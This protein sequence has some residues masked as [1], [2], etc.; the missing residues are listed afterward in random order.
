MI[1]F[2]RI[3]WIELKRTGQKFLRIVRFI[4]NC[5]IL[6]L[7]IVRR[8]ETLLLILDMFGVWGWI[9]PTEFLFQHLWLLN[10][11]FSSVGWDIFIISYRNRW[12]FGSYLSGTVP[13]WGISFSRIKSSSVYLTLNVIRFNEIII[14]IIWRLIKSLLDHLVSALVWW[15]VFNP[16]G[17]NMLAFESLFV[18]WT[19]NLV[20][21]TVTNGFSWFKI[22]QLNFLFVYIFNF[23]C[24]IVASCW[25]VALIFCLLVQIFVVSP[26]WNYWIL[27]VINWRYLRR[28]LILSRSWAW[29]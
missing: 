14:F 11:R 17:N 15:T 10:Q 9:E 16:L 4:L 21:S 8:I 28:N 29:S 18:F 25:F 24:V 2:F 1:K 12:L 7:V 27:K 20:L 23:T 3:I 6:L 22:F 26:S 19:G 13:W 5:S